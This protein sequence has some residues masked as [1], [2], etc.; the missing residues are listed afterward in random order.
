MDDGC[1]G[2][3]AT[4]HNRHAYIDETGPMGN[5]HSQHSLRIHG[6]Y[7][8]SVCLSVCLSV[9]LSVRLYVC[10]SVCQCGGGLAR[11]RV[12]SDIQIKHSRR[13]EDW[14]IPNKPFKISHGA[15]SSMARH[16]GCSQLKQITAT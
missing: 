8:L 15:L 11:A 9:R 16:I 5:Y 4:C 6:K 10:H 13:A 3:T 14:L 1:V 12:R 7:M 2:T